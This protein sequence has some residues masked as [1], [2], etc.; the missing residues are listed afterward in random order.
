[1]PD[2]TL[3]DRAHAWAARREGPR[4]RTIS[5]VA[6]DVVR[7]S[8]QD[9]VTGLAA[10]MAFWA[11]LSFFPLLVTIVALLGYAERV[12]GA[13]QIAEGQRAVVTALSLVFNA[14]I[15]TKVMDPLV[16]GLLRSERGG[17]A[18]TGLVVA[19]YLASRVFTATIRALD[20]AYRVGEGR[21]VIRQRL[22]AL[23]FAVGFAV[24]AVV[25]LLV[26]VLG[27]LLGS[28]ESIADR[29]GMGDAF[30]WL[31]QVLRWPVLLIAIV[32]FLACVYRFG[33]SVQTRLRACLPGAV[34]GVAVWTLAS[35]GLQLYLA[36]GG[37]DATY[38]GSGGAAVALVGRVVGAMVALM[39]WVFLTALAILVGGELNAELARRRATAPTAAAPA[40]RPGSAS[41][42]MRTRE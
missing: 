22:I 11:V 36:A 14:D 28:G 29:L 12:V 27:P 21:G 17:A 10:E 15:T 18:L 25:T 37:G 1:M 23:G 30:S 9:R 4:R 40:V 2:A 20:L 26:M 41:E 3:F 33:P 5:G 42:T 32:L 31:W 16:G 24:V 34:L 19:L 8:V 6:V 13:E 7:N 35:V 38:A 39:L